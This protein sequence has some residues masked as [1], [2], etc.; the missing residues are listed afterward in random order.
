MN[1]V[2]PT[3]DDYLYGEIAPENRDKIFSSIDLMH[4]IQIGKVDA[5]LH[6]H[7]KDEGIANYL[8][9]VRISPNHGV[10]GFYDR[11]LGDPSLQTGPYA[12]K[13][14][15]LD[16]F[17]ACDDEGYNE[18]AIAIS[19]KAVMFLDVNSVNEDG[20]VQ[21]LGVDMFVHHN[22]P[23]AFNFEALVVPVA[24]TATDEPPEPKNQI[25]KITC[26]GLCTL[27]TLIDPE[28]VTKLEK[29]LRPKVND[30]HLKEH[31]PTVTDTEPEKKRTPRRVGRSANV[32]KRSPQSV[33]RAEDPIAV[34]RSRARINDAKGTRKT[35]DS[36]LRGSSIVRTPDK[37]TTST[38]P[39]LEVK[40]VKVSPVKATGWDELF[41]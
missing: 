35:K 16:V 1:S 14:V 18:L 19:Y 40:N 20:D 17:V 27:A 28:Y 11:T 4:K 21:I 13:G 6:I 30:N 2:K 41:N 26:A 9:T 32:G 12:Q 23:N 7:Y 31:V 8:I 15:H 36:P 22:C 25:D 5:H 33:E 10:I 39:N 38:S 37:S 3:L 34:Q 24:Q 29:A